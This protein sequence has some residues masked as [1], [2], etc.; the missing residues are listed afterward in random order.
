V[1]HFSYVFAFDFKTPLAGVNSLLVGLDPQHIPE[2][3]IKILKL[4]E[5]LA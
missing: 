1:R 4:Q 3:S 2:H 5:K